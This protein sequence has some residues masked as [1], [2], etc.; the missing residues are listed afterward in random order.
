VLKKHGVGAVNV[1]ALITGPIQIEYGV[2]IQIE[3]GVPIL[4]TEE[5]NIFHAQVGAEPAQIEDGVPT[6][7]T[8]KKDFFQVKVVIE[9]SQ[10]E[11]QIVF[12]P[13]DYIS[14]TVVHGL[15]LLRAVIITLF[16]LCVPAHQLVRRIGDPSERCQA[17]ESYKNPVPSMKSE[18]LECSRNQETVISKDYEKKYP[19]CKSPSCPEATPRKK[20]VFIKEKSPAPNE[21]CPSVVPRP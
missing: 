8:E 21:L 16:W 3:Y 1:S 20:S 9:P 7:P 5:K 15:D 19:S 6:L 11:N 10:V 2:P 18:S 4:P 12:S 13:N 14:A 17:G